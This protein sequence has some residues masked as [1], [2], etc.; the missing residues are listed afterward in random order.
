[1][2]RKWER[3]VQKNREKANKLRTKGG[4]KPIAT[5]DEADRYTGQSIAL[6]VVLISV[7]ILFMVT[8]QH[9]EKDVFYWITVFGYILLALYFYFLKRPFLKVGRSEIST[10][11]LG[12]EKF[13][14]AADINQIIIQKGYVII[15]MKGKKSQWIFT[16]FFNRFPIERMAE[17]LKEFAA[18]NRVSYKNETESVTS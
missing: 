8:Y 5:P 9:L 6:P 1:M 10:R 15:T 11:R 12:R 4:N 2:S 13:V 16:R 17:R 7:S 18:E 3:M 14:Q